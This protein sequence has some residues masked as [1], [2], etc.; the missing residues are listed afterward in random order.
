MIQSVS[1]I[2]V[3]NVY[4]VSGFSAS[5]NSAIPDLDFSDVLSNALK[6]LD[7]LQK[8]SRNDDILLAAGQ[9]DLPQVMIDA[10]KASIALQTALSIRDKIVNA[11]QEIMRMQL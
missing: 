3:N 8:V 10:E 7:N 5:G 2:G 9:I 11:Y 1:S 4:N 6:E